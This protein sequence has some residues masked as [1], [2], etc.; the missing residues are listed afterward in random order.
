MLRV[1]NLLAVSA[2]QLRINLCLR[3]TLIVNL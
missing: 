3:S 2:I 1:V